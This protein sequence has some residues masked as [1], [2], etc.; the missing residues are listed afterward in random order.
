MIISHK[1]KYLFVEVPHTGS[2][3]I[4][5]ELVA[6]YDGHPILKK[7]SQYIDFLRQASKEE[8]DY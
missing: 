7:H 5:E 3:S 1:Y 2:T 6:N 8:K 4:S